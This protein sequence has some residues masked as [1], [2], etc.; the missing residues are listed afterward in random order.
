MDVRLAILPSSEELD[1]GRREATTEETTGTDTRLKVEF[2]ASP[3]PPKLCDACLDLFQ[4]NMGSLYSSSAWGLNLDEKRKEFEHEDARFLIV[5]R[6]EEGEG[7]ETQEEAEG[8]LSALNEGITNGNDDKSNDIVA[9]THFR[10]ESNDKD[11]PLIEQEVVLYVYEVQVSDIA[12]R[13]GLGRRLMSIMELIAL[14][15][16]GIKKVMLTVFK[17]NQIA[18]DFYLNRMKYDIDESSPSHFA[19]DGGEDTVD[20]EILSK[21]I[22]RKT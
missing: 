3:L 11:I 14:K 8:T 16:M 6:Q 19:E 21:C 2:R 22:G 13:V 4:R 7:G 12:R 5:R 1:G 10:F 18:M 20:Y 9:F 15:R 17:A